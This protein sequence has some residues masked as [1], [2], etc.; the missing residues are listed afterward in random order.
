MYVLR[1]KQI[2][3]IIKWFFITMI[4]IWIQMV[5]DLWLHAYS[6]TAHV[7]QDTLFINL[8]IKMHNCFCSLAY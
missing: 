8:T 1:N 3:F 7:Q 2:E 6:N 5:R 4:D